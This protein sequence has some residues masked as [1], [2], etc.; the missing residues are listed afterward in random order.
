MGERSKSFIKYSDIYQIIYY[1]KHGIARC[2]KY[3]ALRSCRKD[4]Y[5]ALVTMCIPVKTSIALISNMTVTAKHLPAVIA[6]EAWDSSN[7]WGKKMNLES[8]TITAM[9]SRVLTN[10]NILIL[11][12]LHWYNINNMRSRLVIW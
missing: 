1:L 12:C 10:L 3:F 4:T 11:V 6:Y 7:A 9:V 2:I 8:S 5:I